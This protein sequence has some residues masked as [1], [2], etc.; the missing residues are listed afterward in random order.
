MTLGLASTASLL[1]GC[2]PSNELLR[3]NFNSWTGQNEAAVTGTFGYPAKTIDLAGG[4]KLYH[5]DVNK[6]C[7]M[8]FKIDD[9]SIV[10]A[11]DVTG[12]NISDCP[13]KRPGGGSF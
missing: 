10:D 5:Y 13:R 11:V 4:A 3:Q 7:T 9:K 6:H 12:N 1:L 2:G 8:E